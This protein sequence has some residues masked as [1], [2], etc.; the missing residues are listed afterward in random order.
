MATRSPW[1]KPLSPR[2]CPATKK[3]RLG[4][5]RR[6]DTDDRKKLIEWPTRIRAVGVPVVMGRPRHVTENGR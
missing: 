4:R 6:D 5:D 1:M 3:N 2:F